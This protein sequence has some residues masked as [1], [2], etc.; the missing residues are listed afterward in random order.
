MSDLDD[1]LPRDPD[2]D[3]VSPELAALDGKRVW[4][5][6]VDRATGRRTCRKARS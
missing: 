5:G 2:W 6:G 1:A 3:D 4:I